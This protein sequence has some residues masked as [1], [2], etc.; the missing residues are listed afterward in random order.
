MRLTFHKNACNIFV[1]VS[2]WIKV[3][4][5]VWQTSR[6]CLYAVKSIPLLDEP[7][8]LL[9]LHLHSCLK[10]CNFFLWEVLNLELEDFPP[11]LGRAHPF[12]TITEV[13]LILETGWSFEHCI[14]WVLLD[15]QQLKCP[16]VDHSLAEQMLLSET[17]PNICLAHEHSLFFWS[18]IKSTVSSLMDF[19]LTFLLAEM[20]L[21]LKEISC[22]HWNNHSSIPWAQTGK[23]KQSKSS[24]LQWNVS[25]LNQQ[26]LPWPCSRSLE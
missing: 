10:P 12:T 22:K 20:K 3:C 5:K 13:L 9:L 19:F 21:S 15:V 6:M 23:Q 24:L 14:I 7:R 1:M 11:A 25:F 2:K 17:V 18:S 26:R 16:V 8:H 4:Q